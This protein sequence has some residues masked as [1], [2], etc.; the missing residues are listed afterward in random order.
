M[1]S[2]KL[3]SP[4]S[5]GDLNPTFPSLNVASVGSMSLSSS[6]LLGLWKLMR[7]NFYGT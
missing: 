2:A 6:M 7:S 4:K 1:V 3:L 5:L